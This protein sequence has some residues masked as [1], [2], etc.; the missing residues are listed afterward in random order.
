MKL[1]VSLLLCISIVVI[2]C[3]DRDDNLEGVQIRVQ[4]ATSTSFNEVLV[5][6][7]LFGDLQ[8]DDLTF[9]QRYDSLVLPQSVQVFADSL[10]MTIELDSLVELDSTQLFL[11][12]YRIKE[13]SE[14][15]DLEI[16]VLQ[17]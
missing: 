13:M 10:N 16:E 1:I 2:S 8:P 6:T 9:Y 15:M 3:T 17:D 11:F 14:T 7:L 4:N 5:D 12:T